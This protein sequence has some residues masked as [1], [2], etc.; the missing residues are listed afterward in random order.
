MKSGNSN[1][2]VWPLS[3]DLS[4]IIDIVLSMR[5][6]LSD[7]VNVLCGCLVLVLV[8]NLPGCHRG[9]TGEQS[10][11]NG[12]CEGTSRLPIPVRKTAAAGTTH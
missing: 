10:C 1:R 2:A 8:W 3:C 4:K 6:H 11:G 7:K 5:D 12:I 9:R